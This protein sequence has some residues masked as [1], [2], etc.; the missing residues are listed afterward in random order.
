MR[1]ISPTTLSAG[2]S[3]PAARFW[4]ATSWPRFV[5]NIS[6]RIHYVIAAVVVLSFLPAIIAGLRGRFR[7]APHPAALPV[8]ESQQD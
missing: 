6:Q 2:A 1:V 7:R 8:E 5:P 4:E 3:G